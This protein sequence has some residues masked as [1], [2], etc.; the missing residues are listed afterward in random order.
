MTSP[1][2]YYP[3][4]LTFTVYIPNTHSPIVLIGAWLGAL[5]FVT[6]TTFVWLAPK[7]LSI[8]ERLITLWFVTS[9]FIHIIFEGH[10]FRNHK[11]LVSLNDIISQEWKEYAKSD[12]RYL[13]SDSFLLAIEMVTSHVWGPLCLYIAFATANRFPSRHVLTVMMCFAHIYGNVLYYTTTFF[14]G[15]PHS[16]PEFLY[17]WIYFIGVNAFWLVA[18]IT[19]LTRSIRM[20]NI[21]VTKTTNDKDDG[22][23]R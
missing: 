21:A 11:T 16:R 8:T 5:S 1:H 20:I 22:K 19:L 2:P 15:C 10:F 23:N 6:I 4:D 14:E 9:G 12:S 18:P 17:F 3:P 13:S 7:K